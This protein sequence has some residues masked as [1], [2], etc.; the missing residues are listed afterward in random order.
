M[1]NNTLL[2]HIKNIHINCISQLNS[3]QILLNILFNFIQRREHNTRIFILDSR[4]L[5]TTCECS[6]QC[7][8]ISC[9]CLQFPADYKKPQL[10]QLVF[11]S[12]FNETCLNTI[13]QPFLTL[14]DC[15]LIKQVMLRG[16]TL[17]NSTNPNNSI[18][19]TQIA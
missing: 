6:W 1:V 10:Q 11:R 14:A 16:L 4:F 12:D 13:R 15:D 17:R 7:S 19:G 18:I 3:I 2:I 9:I 5:K 8:N